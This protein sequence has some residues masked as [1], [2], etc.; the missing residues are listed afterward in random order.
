MDSY[1]L[2]MTTVVEERMRKP[3]PSRVRRPPG[4][5]TALDVDLNAL[6]LVS[7]AKLTTPLIAAERR[8]AEAPPVTTSTPRQQHLRDQCPRRPNCV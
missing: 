3:D 7:V 5:N 6:N 1:S 8:L 2:E 4:C